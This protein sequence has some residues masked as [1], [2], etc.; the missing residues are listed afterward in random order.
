MTVDS[1][2]VLA[3][4]RLLDL[5]KDRGFS[6]HR[7]APGEDGPLFGR[8]ETVDWQDEVYLGGFSESCSA[9]RRRRY[10][11]VVPGGIPI[12]KRVN[13]SVLHVLRIVTDWPT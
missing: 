2:D 10:S 5:A 3:A 7:I 4:K 1:P 8:R 13:G 6:F 11:L 9:V 12:A